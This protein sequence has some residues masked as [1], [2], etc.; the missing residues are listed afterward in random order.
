MSTK[1]TKE[2]CERNCNL[3]QG[4]KYGCRYCYARW[5]SH[6]FGR[7]DWDDW[8]VAWETTP[9]QN[10]ELR[11]CS[12]RVLIAST[13]DVF[14]EIEERYLEAMEIHLKKGNSLLMVSKPYLKAIKT[15]CETLES[16]RKQIMFRFTITSNNNEIL[17]HWEPFAPLYKER[18]EALLYAHNVD[19]QTSISCEPYLK[20]PVQLYNELEEYVTDTFWIGPMNY[21]FYTSPREDPLA[22]EN[23]KE[24]TRMCAQEK[25]RL[26]ELYDPTY[27][28]HIA[29]ET[30]HFPKI[31]YKDH[32]LNKLHKTI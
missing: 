26:T 3:V 24:Y 20:T 7:I 29:Q 21:Y 13:H 5:M 15:I 28:K 17:T 18:K 23:L 22:R 6:R 31:K 11:K 8:T 27:I 10:I 2:W 14:P 9:I 30:K 19:F 25:E 16:Y 4:C 12:G 32:F 1:G